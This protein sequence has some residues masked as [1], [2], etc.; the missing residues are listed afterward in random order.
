MTW[1]VALTGEVGV[2]LRKHLL[3]DDGQEDVCLATYALSTGLVRRTA[4][5]RE[6][7]FPAPGERQVHG[8]AAF[9]GEYVI[10]VAS[11]AAAD[12]LGV[13]IL[14]SHPGASGWQ[15]MSAL[16][17]DAERSFAYLVHEMTGLPLVGLTLAGT[18]RSWSARIWDKGGSPTACESVRVVDEILTVF[19]NEALRP[20]PP[21]QDTQVRT[22]SGWGQDLQADI[23][24][25][26]LLIVGA[27]SVGL[28]VALR[29][30]ATGVETIGVMDFDTV[31]LLNLDR[32]IGASPVDAMLYRSK[33]ELAAKL[34]RITA[35]APHPEI[36]VFEH[37]I[38][39]SVG[40]KAALDFDVIFSCVDRPWP[41][42]VLNTIAYADLIPVIDGGLHIDPFP[43]GGMRNA[44]WRS[45]VVRPGRPCLSCNRQLDLG[46]VSL[47]REGLL[48]DPT[49]INR[50][51]P[52]HPARENVA[53]LSASVTSS[54]LAQFVSL[55]AA[56]GS[57]GEPGPLQYILSTHTLDH[58][59]YET[60][61]GCRFE[62]ATADGDRRLSLTGEDKRAE[63]GRRA[64]LVASRR[65]RIRLGR[66]ADDFSSRVS[67]RVS[68]LLQLR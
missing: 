29:L 65:F 3:R 33:A 68:R 20:T 66:L 22:A 24:R 47:D 16:D 10:R 31:E 19:W 42:A 25:L 56:P 2:S 4:L 30:A 49:Y 8:N 28:E 37:S 54:L 11:G 45:H 35:T 63:E 23:A 32:L 50:A 52:Q 60:A 57:V 18:D 48:N 34:L 38:C 17:E 51:G 26:R 1:S 62:R 14:H 40:Q 43:E 21:L 39:E 27:G 53:L 64:R 12:G 46:K 7:Q 13:A 58:L 15:G 44:T 5:L 67:A 41:R 59:Q 36:Q 61:P 9:K 55:A 6:S